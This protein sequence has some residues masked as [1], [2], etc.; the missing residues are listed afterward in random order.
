MRPCIPE[1]RQ[2]LAQWWKGSPGG[3][4]DHR[5]PQNP[6]NAHRPQ[7]PIGRSCGS[8]HGFLTLVSCEALV[9]YVLN[10]LKRGSCVE[11][12]DGHEEWVLCAMG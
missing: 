4:E 11:P 5:H 6:D 3:G 10:T 12:T 1:G 9:C 2:D 8:S 7:K